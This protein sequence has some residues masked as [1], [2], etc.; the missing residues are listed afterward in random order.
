[1]PKKGSNFIPL[2]LDTRLLVAV[3]GKASQKQQLNATYIMS[4]LVEHCETDLEPQAYNEL[5]QRYSKTVYEQKKE[6]QA[7]AKAKLDREEEQLRL[8]RK[9]LEIKE[10]TSKAYQ[11]QTR[12]NTENEIAELNE[13]LKRHQKTLQYK[14]STEGEKRN[15]TN[16]IKWIHTQ[17]KQ[18]GVDTEKKQTVSNNKIDKIVDSILESEINPTDTTETEKQSKE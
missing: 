17:L 5:K 7:K 14:K 18:L 15:A 1:M 16:S 3:N 10:R 2:V 6:K 11:N 8:K 13:D 9:E 4:V 12:T